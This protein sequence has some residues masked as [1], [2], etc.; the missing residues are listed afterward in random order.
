MRDYQAL[1]DGKAKPQSIF[2]AVV[3]ADEFKKCWDRLSPPEQDFLRSLNALLREI[4]PVG[5]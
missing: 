4:A 2:D 1:L 3:E 5:K